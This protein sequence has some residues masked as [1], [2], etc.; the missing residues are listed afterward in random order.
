MFCAMAMYAQNFTVRGSVTDEKGEPVIGASVKVAGTTGAV[1][2]VDGYYT[3]DCA[4]NSVLEVSYIGFETQNVPV[5]G[6]ST[7]DVVMYETTTS[8]GEVVV[9]ALGI[10]KDAR[11][12][13][14]SVATVGAEES[15][16][17]SPLEMPFMNT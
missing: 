6:R 3:I 13:G 4:P 1:T 12:L 9:T 10:K 14:Y 8:L 5:N 16:R 2:N 17:R 11:K 15:T 7:V